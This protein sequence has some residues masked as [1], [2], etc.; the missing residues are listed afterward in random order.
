MATENSQ[1]IADISANKVSLL[2]SLMVLLVS[3]MLVTLSWAFINGSANFSID[4]ALL[5][6]LPVILLSGIC[7]LVFKILLTARLNKLTE[8]L[9]QIDETLP[10]L[11]AKRYDKA[12]ESFHTLAEAATSKQIIS[13]SEQLLKLSTSMAAIDEKTAKRAR[14]NFSQ[15]DELRQQLQ[16]IRHLISNAQML[17]MT[18]DD[19]MEVQ[20]FNTYAEQIT[21]VAADTI[22]HMGVGNLLSANDWQ[23]TQRY[24]HGLLYGQI[25]L[26]HQETEIIDAD[27]HLRNIWWLHSMLDDP[28][29]KLIL[30]VGHDVTEEKGVEKRVVWLAAHDALTGALNAAKFQELFAESLNNAER[31]DKHHTL[32]Y[33]HTDFPEYQK[34]DPQL[35]QQ[36]TDEMRVSIA[37]ALQKITRQTDMLARINEHDFAILQPETTDESR[38][39]FTEKIL[40][41]LDD[42]ALITPGKKLPLHFY[43]GVIDYPYQKAE[44][45]ELLAFAELAAVRAKHES[46][47]VSASHVFEPSEQT[48]KELKQRV[49][50]K[51]RIQQALTE[52]RFTVHYQPILE[53]KTQRI[54][55]HEGYLRLLDKDSGE[56][57]PAGNFIEIAEKQGLVEEIDQLV[58]RDIFARAA[59]NRRGEQMFFI[60][61]SVQSLQPNKLLP[62]I[63]KLLEHHKLEG[64]QIVIEINET[65]ISEQTDSLKLLMTAL[66]PLSVRFAID[67]FGFDGSVSKYGFASFSLLQALPVAFVKINGRFI[68][69]LH[70]NIHDQLF[71]K[72]LVDE[73]SARGVK[74]I[75]ECVENEEVMS[76]LTD[77]GVDYAQGYFIGHPASALQTE[78]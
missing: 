37:E 49:F 72:T 17:I 19:A 59:N 8:P 78:F 52:N 6:L 62:R 39:L 70:N 9:Q 42:L 64:R 2:F 56:A 29:K 10:L 57:L 48:A 51:K 4:T 65:V 32:L 7:G 33:L 61:L 11:L 71:V 55:G 58:L 31:Y 77:S 25:K 74:I 5:I 12:D 3:T 36:M 18:V 68:R 40:N 21:G 15:S 53:L 30:S 38:R 54:A 66:K 73:A 28:D 69:D 60:N 27:G 23:D 67:D 16:H 24:Y 26:A 14:E 20:F 43:I 35:T 1:M 34:Q 76:F 46:A 45:S 47:K 41:H 50:W 75:A 13:I 63:K 22:T 44:T